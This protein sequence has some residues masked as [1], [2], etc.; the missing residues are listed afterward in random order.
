MLREFSQ[1]S[2]RHFTAHKLRTFLTVL[3]VALGISATIGMWLVEGTASRIFE[4]IVDGLQGKAQLEVS[5]GQSGIAEDLLDPIKALPGVEV[6]TGAVRGFV[7]VA[8]LKGERLF[9]FGVDLLADSKVHQYELRSSGNGATF[10][11]PL[12]FL[13]QPDSVALTSE[14]LKRHSLKQGDKIRVSG[15][16]GAV[17]LTIRGEL[18]VSKGPATLFNGR[19][20]LMDVFAAERLFGFNHR[21]SEI[22]VVPK[23]GASLAVRAALLKVVGERGGVESTVERER[24][25]D[26]DMAGFRSAYTFAGILAVVIGIYLIFNTMTIAV[27][28]RRREI[29]ILRAVCMRRGELLRLIA[30]ESMLIGGL[31]AVLGIALGYG[32]AQAILPALAALMQGQEF[33]RDLRLSAQV[34]PMLWAVVL[35][36]V[37][38]LVASLLP[39]REAVS[40]QPVEAIR[41]YSGSVNSGE[42]YR[43]AGFA[44]AGC[45]CAAMLSWLMRDWAPAVM[46]NQIGLLAG[47]SLLAP[48][49]VRSLALRTERVFS[50]SSSPLMALAGRNIAT[51]LSR[52]TISASALAVSIAGAVGAATILSSMHV[53]LTKQIDLGFG[54]VDLIIASTPGSF[55]PG[56]SSD[57]LPLPRSVV[58]E[59][60]ELSGVARVTA[61]RWLRVPLGDG[62]SELVVNDFNSG[63]LRRPPDVIKGRLAEPGRGEVF[64]GEQVARR[65]GL[66]VGSELKLKTP[67]GGAAFRVSGIAYDA[68]IAGWIGLPTSVYRQLWKDDTV[69]Q[70]L[71]RLKPGADLDAVSDEIRNRFGDRYA[72]TLLAT[73]RFRREAGQA[74]SMAMAGAYPIN[75]M[76][77]AIALLG[78]VN[79]LM[80]TILARTREFGVLRATVAKRSELL[81]MIV[82]EAATI[83]LGSGV[84]GVSVGSFMG[85]AYVRG[86]FPILFHHVPAYS[87][88]FGAAAFALVGA[89]VL[90]SLAGYF[91]GR[92]A[93]RLKIVEA[94]A[95]E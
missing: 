37:S 78:V 39:A 61:E 62:E 4:H 67:G 8:T 10:K 30:L 60:A 68:S 86:A 20:A 35:G 36:L 54:D 70:I 25:L 74:L 83:G 3:G 84:L 72:L 26:R 29:G 13:A 58:G 33:I 9:V 95:Y 2:L 82:A 6:A 48:A 28:Q 46:I 73:G 31:G 49:V 12:V 40:V 15:T 18:G 16:V 41:G 52:I 51:N 53:D 85:Y 93:A 76:A 59:L 55:N 7:P 69:N 14:F 87:Y 89:V 44:G 22:D 17:N 45:I 63:S 27:A 34:G 1:I 43:W 23:A 80:A 77:I 38:A 94:L 42:L 24:A 50:F 66:D 91:P 65:L 57:W 92:R 47:V 75:A 19:L 56:D 79:S 88:P 64:V 32:F 11:D 5:N 71:L 90:S 21:F 81:A